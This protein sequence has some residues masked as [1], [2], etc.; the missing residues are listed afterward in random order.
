MGNMEN[1]MLCFFYHNKKNYPNAQYYSTLSNLH[2]EGYA[3]GTE[4]HKAATSD[5]SMMW[6]FG[7]MSQF[8]PTLR[9]HPSSR[10]PAGFQRLL[11]DS[12]L[13]WVFQIP[14]F[15]TKSLPKHK[16]GRTTSQ[17][18]P[19]F[20]HQPQVQ[21]VPGPTSFQVQWLQSW[22]HPHFNISLEGFRWAYF[23]SFNNAI[24]WLT[25][26]KKVLYLEL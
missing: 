18:C 1:P 4:C 24:E 17:D 9:N 6:V 7:S 12:N 13:A 23:L 14:F 11:M 20:R 16:A 19:H 2:L 21:V 22:E 25:E 10:A 8:Q 3:S 5:D 15:H 26:L